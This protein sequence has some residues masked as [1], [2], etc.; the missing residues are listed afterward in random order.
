MRTCRSAPCATSVTAW[1]ISPTARPASSEVAAICCEAED[2]VPAD[3]E[4]SPIS[5]LSASRVAL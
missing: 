5:A 3:I 4:T 2:T 1:A